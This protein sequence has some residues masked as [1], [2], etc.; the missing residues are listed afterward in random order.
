MSQLPQVQIILELRDQ[1]VSPGFLSTVA[2][3]SIFATWVEKH[4]SLAYYYFLFNVL[5]G[6]L[7]GS[8]K[9]ELPMYKKKKKTSKDPI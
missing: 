4:Q 2:S 6:P 7:I 5:F 8:T 1:V 3:T 9:S